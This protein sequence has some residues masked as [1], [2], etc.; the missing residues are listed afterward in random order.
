MAMLDPGKEVENFIK[1]LP[2]RTLELSFVL[3]FGNVEMTDN[4]DVE[5]EY[6]GGSAESPSWVN[7]KRF[8]KQLNSKF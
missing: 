2:E 4:I 8:A 6:F 1:V 3:S 5:L 7:F